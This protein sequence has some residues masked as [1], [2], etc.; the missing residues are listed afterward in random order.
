MTALDMCLGRLR[1]RWRLIRSHGSELNR[2]VE[3]EN[4]LLSVAAGKRGPLSPDECR[5]LGLKLGT[6]REHWPK[7]WR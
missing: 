2:R 7:E 5:V 1:A 3:V 4:V 6:P